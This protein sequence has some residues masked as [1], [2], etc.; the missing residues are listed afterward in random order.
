MSA[1]STLLAVLTSL[2]A[3]YPEITLQEVIALACVAQSEGSRTCDI[4][5]AGDM[6][7]STASRSV[8]ALGPPASPW[9]L[10][11]ALGLVEAFL[12]ADDGRNRALYLSEAGRRLCGQ[13]DEAFQVSG[14]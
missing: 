3:Q 14:E 8:R 6:T 12:A 10:E 4:V 5:V 7:Q 1:G 9:S 11:P 2:K 13:L